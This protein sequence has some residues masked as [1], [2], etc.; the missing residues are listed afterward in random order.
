MKK[1]QLK[2]ST[3]AKRA[4]KTPRVETSEVF[5]K[6]ALSCC[7]TPFNTVEGSSGAGLPFCPG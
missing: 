1:Q 7:V 3:V 5:N 6:A 4:W 2:K